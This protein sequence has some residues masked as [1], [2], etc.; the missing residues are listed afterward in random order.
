M[1][2]SAVVIFRPYPFEVGQKIY[3]EDGPRHGDWEVIAVSD[4]KVTLRCPFSKR[5]FAW[6]RFCY[7]AETREDI[8]WPHPE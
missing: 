8:P 7:V 6:N 1:G 3:I 2:T 5:E 4:R